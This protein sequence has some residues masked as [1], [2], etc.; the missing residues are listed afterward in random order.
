MPAGDDGTLKQ[1]NEIG[2]FIPL[3]DALAPAVLVNKT[4]TADALLTQRL[5]ASDL[6]AR[7]AHFVFTVK[8]NQ[9]KLLE[10]LQWG[11]AQRGAPHFREATSLQHG[12]I[13]SRAIWT[14]TALNDYLVH[15][16]GFP[17]IAQAFVIERQRTHKK[18]GKTSVELAYGITSRTPDSATP[19][20]VLAL[21]R[22]HWSIE[23]RC[24]WPLDWTWDEDRSTI[25][26][27]YGPE[28]TSRLR[29]FAIGVIRT[30]SKAGVA[31]TIRRLTRHPRLVFDF[32]GMTLNSTR[33]TNLRG[34]ERTN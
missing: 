7:Q 28:N 17:G 6:I 11:F 1:T 15:E 20:Q 12:R 21:N 4:V 29:R 13:E 25:R 3:L 18:S 2:T 30:H 10:A 19:A 5:L 14:T 26:T 22:N 8:A 9:P 23:N 16:L 32:L 34:E 33:S 31:P 27:G 24:H